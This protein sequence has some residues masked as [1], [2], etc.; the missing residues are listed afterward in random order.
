MEFQVTLE[1]ENQFIN[2]LVNTGA[3]YSV[4]NTRLIKLSQERMLIM[5]V[6]EKP[7]QKLFLQPLD[8]KMGKTYLRHS[9]LYVPRGSHSAPG[10]RFTDQIEWKDIF[11]LGWIDIKFFPEKAYA[12]QVAY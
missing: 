3:T 7:Q 4:L 8:F 5:G 2:F 9:F 12:L 11:A 10:M 6:S 1:V